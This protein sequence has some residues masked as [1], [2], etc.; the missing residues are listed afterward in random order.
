VGAVPGA[1]AAA[2]VNVA[3]RA[4]AVAKLVLSTL[5]LPLS[6]LTSARATVRSVW[7]LTRSVWV[8]VRAVCRFAIAVRNWANWSAVEDIV[9][10]SGIWNGFG[11]FVGFDGPGIGESG[12]S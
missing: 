7:V 3:M 9:G 5:T 10:K 2:A 8:L 12:G 4:L 6:I 11:E 1:G